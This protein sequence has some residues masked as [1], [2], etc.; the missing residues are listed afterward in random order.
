MKISLP[1]LPYHVTLI[2]KEGFN[3]EKKSLYN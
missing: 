3:A 2:T 1:V